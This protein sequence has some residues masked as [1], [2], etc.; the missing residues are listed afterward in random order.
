MKVLLLQSVIEGNF[1]WP[2]LSAAHSVLKQSSSDYE[3]VVDAARALS[4]PLQRL[5]AR[6]LAVQT[7]ASAKGSVTPLFNHL[8]V[9]NHNDLVGAVD[10][11]KAVGD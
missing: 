6:I 2:L 4:H 11:C 10:R 1:C 8:A 5:P 9:F 7:G 3:T